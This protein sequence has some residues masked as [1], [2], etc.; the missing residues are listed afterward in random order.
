VLF[1]FELTWDADI[2]GWGRGEPTC[3]KLGDVALGTGSDMLLE[4]RGLLTTRTLGYAYS[5]VNGGQLPKRDVRRLRVVCLK[6]HCC[7]VASPEERWS[8][9]RT[10]S[11]VQMVSARS[12]NATRSLWWLGTSVAMS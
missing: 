10:L 5:H 4:L 2:A 1:S 8:T 12:S 6:G 7:V 9:I 3:R 11:W